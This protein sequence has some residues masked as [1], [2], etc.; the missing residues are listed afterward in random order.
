MVGLMVSAVGLGYLRYGKT[1]AQPLLIVTGLLL[2]VIPW[3]VTDALWLSV[4]GIGIAAASYVANKVLF[5]GA[6]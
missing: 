6:M 4:A 1:T 3:A 5:P 2:L